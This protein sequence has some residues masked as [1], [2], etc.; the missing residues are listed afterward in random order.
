MCGVYYHEEVKHSLWGEI[1]RVEAFENEYGKN[2]RI[3]ENNGR[4]KMKNTGKISMSEK[5]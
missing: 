2:G 5:E 1:D 4:K 3:Q